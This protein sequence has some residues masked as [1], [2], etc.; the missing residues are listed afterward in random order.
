MAS[1]YSSATGSH[2]AVYAGS[3]TSR[4]SP[5]FRYPHQPFLRRLLVGANLKTSLAK[6]AVHH[7][8]HRAWC[9]YVQVSLL[10]L[11]AIALT[12][13][14]LP[15]GLGLEWATPRELCQGREH[16]LRAVAG[17]L[18]ALA[19]VS[20]GAAFVARLDR[21][22]ECASAGAAA[23]YHGNKSAPERMLWPAECTREKVTESL[24][25]KVCEPEVRTEK[26]E[27]LELNGVQKA[28]AFL[29]G[30]KRC[31]TVW[32][33][34]VCSD[35]VDTGAQSELL[36]LQE[37]TTASRNKSA[38]L[39]KEVLS[40]ISSVSQPNQRMKDVVSKGVARVDFASNVY[41]GYAILSLLLGRPLVVFKRGK[42]T[43]VSGIT[44]GLSKATFTVLVV[45]VITVYDSV[46]TL[47]QE[48]D[49]KELLKNFHSDPCYADPEFSRS[50]SDSIETTC[51]RVGVLHVETSRRVRHLNEIRH[52]IKLF[53]LC[54]KNGERAVHPALKFIDAKIHLYRSGGL[55]NPAICNVTALNRATETPSSSR[56][57]SAIESLLGSGVLAQLLAKLIVTNFVVQIVS[58]CEPLAAHGG[59]VE[60]WGEES[61]TTEEESSVKRFA[62]DKHLL[63]VCLS[64]VS[65]LLEVALFAYASIRTIYGE[66][67]D[68]ELQSD[69]ALNVIAE[70]LT[71]ESCNSIYGL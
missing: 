15:D 47:L 39:E 65:I 45:V 43:R 8:P 33:D 55:K 69:G 67:G 50:R 1:S 2:T 24:T 66:Y 7:I 29:T 25:K 61:M 36:A 42:R 27:C 63:P 62:R 19:N 30:V 4:P 59:K 64:I 56:R 3:E 20:A 14:L 26:T 40:T 46:S 58:Y 71:L 17:R 32:V 13:S 52:K 44:L 70:S 12:P 11:I 16:K 18:A 49:L 21:E 48:S 51:G 35:V 57:T 23:F 6:S 31:K 5:R 34:P 53:G 28:A 38:E 22:I 60:L 54:E 37:E 9:K 41:I 68:N 10:L